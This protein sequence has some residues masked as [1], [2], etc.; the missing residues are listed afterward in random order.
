LEGGRKNI[1]ATFRIVKYYN[2]SI[3]KQGKTKAIN[4]NYLQLMMQQ[5]CEQCALLDHTNTTS[6]Q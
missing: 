1:D 5:K 6:V 2:I 4:K 3:A